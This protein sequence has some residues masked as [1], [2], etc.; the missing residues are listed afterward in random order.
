MEREDETLERVIPLRKQLED[1]EEGLRRGV[2]LAD[3]FKQL[4]GVVKD[5]VIHSESDVF[6]EAMNEVSAE[7]ARNPVIPGRVDLIR[8]RGL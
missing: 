3:S 5:I 1:I 4:L 8:Q 7:M 2:P 6:E